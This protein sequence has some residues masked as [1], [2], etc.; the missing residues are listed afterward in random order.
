MRNSYTDWWTGYL[1]LS[2]P[3]SPFNKDSSLRY[4]CVNEREFTD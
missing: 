4:T 2:G 3:V 1:Q